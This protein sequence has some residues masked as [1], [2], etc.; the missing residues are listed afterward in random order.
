MEACVGQSHP[1]T[2]D[3]GPRSNG[4]NMEAQAGL[5]GAKAATDYAYLQRVGC[6][7]PQTAGTQIGVGQEYPIWGFGDASGVHMLS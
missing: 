5:P 6:E 4:R 7:W 2:L 1:T 3:W